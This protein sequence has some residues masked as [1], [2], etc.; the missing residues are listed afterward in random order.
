MLENPAHWLQA[1][2]MARLEPSSVLPLRYARVKR[3]R[4]ATG[5]ERLIW[6]TPMTTDGSQ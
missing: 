3:L 2:V 6:P 4:A 5:L 1:H